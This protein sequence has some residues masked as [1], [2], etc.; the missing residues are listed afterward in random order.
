MMFMAVVAL[1]LTPPPV[2]VYVGPLP[3]DGFVDIDKGVQDSIKDLRGALVNN[4]HLRVVDSEAPAILKLYVVSRQRSAGPSGGVGIL[5]NGT[6]TSVSAPS[7][8]YSLEAILRVG[9]YE[10]T[11]TAEANSHTDWRGNWRGCARQIAKDLTTWLVA[12]REHIAS[13]R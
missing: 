6:G 9:P 8:N 3:R 2:T 10:R 13:A 7:N 12:N 1:F 5:A 11:F 4:R